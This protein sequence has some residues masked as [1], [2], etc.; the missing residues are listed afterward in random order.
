[1]YVPGV[2]ADLVAPVEVGRRAEPHGASAYGLGAADDD[3]DADEG[4]AGLA[5]KEDAG[6]GAGLSEGR[7]RRQQE[8]GGDRPA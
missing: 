2:E 5:V 7:H 6:D 1:V 4:L 8:R 3:V